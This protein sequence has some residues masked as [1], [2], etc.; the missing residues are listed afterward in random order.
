M[1]I[2]AGLKFLT[3]NKN[4]DNVESLKLLYQKLGTV[5]KF[6]DEAA[7]LIQEIIIQHPPRVVARIIDPEYNENYSDEAAEDFFLYVVATTAEYHIHINKP[8][9]GVIW[10]LLGLDLY[11]L[12]ISRHIYS[13]QEHIT[14]KN[15]TIFTLRKILDIIEQNMEHLDY[16]KYY[17]SDGKRVCKFEWEDD[18]FS[19][20]KAANENEELTLKLVSD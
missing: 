16:Y 3:K 12:F 15:S 20:L 4:L 14:N 19:N 11:D 7:F 18:Y 6:Y 2:D 17:D 9:S 13:K 8:K 5:S 1:V 10:A